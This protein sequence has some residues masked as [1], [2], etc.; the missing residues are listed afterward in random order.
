M[1]QLSYCTFGLTELTLAE[2]I[3]AVDR[4]GYPGV[5]LSFHRD[6]FNPFEI[7]PGTLAALCR[8][9]ERLAVRPACVATA[10]HFFTPARP[11]EPSLMCP[12]LA[13][14]KRRIGLVSRGI[15]VAR[16]LDIPLVTFGS[17]FVRAEHL[18][19]PRIDP[20]AL[21]VDS[22]R[23]CLDELRPDDDI[24]LLIEPEPGM[25]IE[26]MDQAIALVNEIDSPHFG[27]HLDLCHVYCSEKD[28]VAAVARAAPYTRYLHVSDA[29][30]GCNLKIIAAPEAA[31]LD[32]DFADY[33]VYFPET[34]S[35]L[36][37]D[38][39]HPMF[40]G[41]EPPGAAESDHMARLAGEA[42]IEARTAYVPYRS[43]HAGATEFDDEVFTYLISVP[44]LSFD[45][46][47]RARPVINFLRGTR[48]AAGQPLMGRRVANTLTG[49]V[50]YHDIPGEGTLDF[51]A[52][53]QAL[54]ENGFSGYA[55]VELYH[56]VGL[57][58]KALQ[59]SYRHLSQFV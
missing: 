19:D 39:A 3:E 48:D 6:Q 33:L 45:V 25:H 13:G 18:I 51:A 49:I 52:C 57:W 29:Q 41:D 40:F 38:R 55:S 11:H 4:A 31:S 50:H 37:L 15:E 27:L 16:E 28:Y 1:I 36:L 56:H 17:G 2:A 42:G 21:L 46:L 5:E 22:V 12:D 34:A 43:L 58:E 14:R 44:R 30:A 47:E 35:F 53:F 7:R 32:L 20:H 26:T 8:Q 23:R 54:N 24:T 59:A 10:S 9:F